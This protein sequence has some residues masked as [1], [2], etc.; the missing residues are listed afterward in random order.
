MQRL[1]DENRVPFL[2][3]LGSQYLVLAAR[4]PDHE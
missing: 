4:V 2:R 1:A 3:A